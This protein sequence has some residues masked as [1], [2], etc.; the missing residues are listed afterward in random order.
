MRSSMS[1]EKTNNYQE[2]GLEIPYEQL[3]PGVA[4][5]V[6]YRQAVWMVIGYA[7]LLIASR[8]QLRYLDNIAISGVVPEPS[9]FALIGLAGLAFFARRRR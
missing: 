8:V 7:A 3:D 5:G 2:K 4:K 1:Q 9:T 6:F